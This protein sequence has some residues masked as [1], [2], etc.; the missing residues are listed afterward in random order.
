MA[1]YKQCI[2]I[3]DDLKLSK[4]KLAV[5]VA[6]AAVSAAEWAGRSDLEKWKEGGQKKV[7]LRAEKLQDLFELK[8][9][10]RREGL[11]TALITDAGLTEIAP[12]TVTVL[13]IGP[14]KAEAID[15][16]TGSLKL[17]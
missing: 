11:A 6:H 12:G 15:K 13:G 4:G 3:R 2:V 16:I 8:E 1:E 14:A 10:A 7:V 9:K 17:L 5:Q